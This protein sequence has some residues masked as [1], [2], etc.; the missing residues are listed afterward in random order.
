MNLHVC[1]FPTTSFYNLS[2]FMITRHRK[3]VSNFDKQFTSERTELTPTDK[4][5][6]MNLDQTEFLGFSYLNPEYIQHV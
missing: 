2:T 3:D 5:F 4:L 6:M 1:H